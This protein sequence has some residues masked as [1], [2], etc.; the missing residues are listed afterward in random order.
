MYQ[1]LAFVGRH[2]VPCSRMKSTRDNERLGGPVP[3]ID[4][5]AGPGGLGEGFSAFEAEG[6]SQFSV[7]ISIEKDAV[8]CE[9]LRLRALTRQFRAPP[10]KIL[11]YM[12]GRSP[13]S[14][15]FAAYPKEAMEADIA[16]R[17]AELGHA[18]HAQVSRAVRSRLAGASNWVLLGGPPYQTYSIAGRSR[19]RT[20]RADFE[21]DERHFLYRE[22]L[23]I[24]AEHEPAVFVLENVKGLIT[25]KHGGSHI[26]TKILDDL[27][28]PGKVVGTKNNTR[29]YRLYALGKRQA[30]FWWTE[31]ASHDGEDFI[32]KA[33]DYGVPQTRHRLFIVGVRADVA[34]RPGT[35]QSRATVAASAVL[36]DLPQIRSQLTREPDSLDAWRAAVSDISNSPWMSGSGPGSISPVRKEIRRII[37][38]LRK[39]DLSVGEAYLPHGRVP[40]ALGSWYRRHDVGLMHHEARAHMRSDLH[41]YMFAAA[42]ARIHSRSPELQ[43]FPEALRPAH[44]NV[45]RALEGTGMFNDRFRVQLANRPSMT[46]TSHISKDGHY[47]IHYAPLQCRSLTVREAARLQTFPDDYYFEGNRTEQYHQIG[48]AVPPLLAYDI[49]QIVYDLL[50]GA[51]IA[52]AAARGAGA[53]GRRAAAR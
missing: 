5:F 6:G 51:G 7:R 35:L 22:Y 50:A 46:I 30:S 43:H 13:R 20:T 11:D 15:A 16:V 40:R 29:G 45:S 12:A 1:R 3:V 8:A 14:E 28:E 47:Y 34:G 36:C 24:V 42:Y 27:S 21:F 38:E 33:E 41:R 49:A 26:V 17:H 39:R 31:G 4:L 9:T 44:R 23:R 53:G 18:S 10:Q 48:N 19:M 37:T 2:L 25:S 32:V 52:R